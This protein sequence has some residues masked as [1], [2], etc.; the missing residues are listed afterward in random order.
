MIQPLIVKGRNFLSFEALELPLN[1]QGVFRIDGYNGDKSSADSNGAGKSTLFEIIFWVLYGKSLRKIKSAEVVRRGAGK[2][3]TWGS[4]EFIGSDGIHYIIDRYYKDFEYKNNLYLYPKGE[5]REQS[6][7]R[8][9]DKSETQENIIKKIGI[10]AESFKQIVL[11]GEN[12]ET[13]FSELTDSKRKKLLEEIMNVSIYEEA[14]SIARKKVSAKKKE[15][16]KI[17]IK[18]ESTQS[19]IREY[20]DLY[21]KRLKEKSQWIENQENTFKKKKK[22]LESKEN[23][24][25]SLPDIEESPE[26][27][28]DEIL[29]LQ[30]SH[31]KK[32]DELK[33]KSNSISEKSRERE[34]VI[35]LNNNKLEIEMDSLKATIAETDDL[36]FNGICPTCKQHTDASV[37]PSIDE[38]REKVTELRKKRGLNRE[39][40]KVLSKAKRELISDLKAKETEIQGHIEKNDQKIIKI[41]RQAKKDEK[42]RLKKIHLKKEIEDLRNEISSWVPEEYPHD[43]SIDSLGDMIDKY[44]EKLEDQKSN[45]HSIS[46]EM[47]K[48]DVITRIFGVQGIRSFIIDQMVDDFNQSLNKYTEIITSGQI[49]AYITTQSTTSSGDVREMIDFVVTSDGEEV[50]YNS[51][52]SGEKRR[53]DLPVTFAL[54][55]IAA[56]FGS[57]LGFC[58]LDEPFENVD[59]SGIYGIMEL[60]KNVSMRPYTPLMLTI[61]HS[62]EMSQAFHSSIQVR[63]EDGISTVFVE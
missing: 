2:D 28:I 29:E 59:E 24:F 12:G 26:D 48:L 56:K 19:S 44:K 37:F 49:S 55:D 17:T 9:Q 31:R 18:L 13:R 63:K 23:E 32:I 45:I 1:K 41:R 21:A 40:L 58:L 60:L 6:S 52:S 38:M 54:Q 33:D 39:N 14:A 25:A 30:A 35:I 57:G 62:P 16:E 5:D 61:T 8:S 11:F 3:G 15:I 42:E 20:K 50:S 43:D 34:N 4:F 22:T 46:R 51:C 10:S 7:L 27:I 47:Q 53:L 36:I